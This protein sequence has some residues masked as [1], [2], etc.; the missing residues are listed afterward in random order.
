MIKTLKPH[1]NSLSLVIE[2]PI[3]EL[4]KIN[5]HTYLEITTDGKSLIVTPKDDRDGDYRRKAEKVIADGIKKVG[6]R[7]KGQSEE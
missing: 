5:E 4:L 7:H 3:L 2:K 1:G 6:N